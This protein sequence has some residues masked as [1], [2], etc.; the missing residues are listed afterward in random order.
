MLD[1]NQISVWASS[2]S[3]NP[4]ENVS[5]Y[6]IFFQIKQHKSKISIILPSRTDGNLLFT[7]FL[8]SSAKVKSL[9]TTKTQ[10]Q[11]I[12]CFVSDLNGYLDCCSSC[13]RVRTPQRLLPAPGRS[14]PSAAFWPE[15]PEVWETSG[16]SSHLHFSLEV[17]GQNVTPFYIFQQ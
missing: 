13:E 6:Q 1:C 5:I 10:I 7:V 4:E 11:Q 2:F 9:E 16:H 14:L 17:R 3:S 15:T 8:K 12:F